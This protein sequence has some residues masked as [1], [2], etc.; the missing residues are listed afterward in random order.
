[1][2]YHNWTFLLART[3]KFAKLNQYDL[4]GQ[5]HLTLT[6]VEWDLVFTVKQRFSMFGLAEYLRVRQ[7]IAG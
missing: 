6:G 3:S 7:R 2:A 5:C 4:V 1:M